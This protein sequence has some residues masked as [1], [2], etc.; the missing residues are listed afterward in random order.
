MPVKLI[1]YCMKQCQSAEG[2]ISWYN[3]CPKHMFFY[4]VDNNS[5]SKMKGVLQYMISI[6]PLA[7]P[8]RSPSCL[9]A[10]KCLIGKGWCL[11]HW[12][13]PQCIV[14]VWLWALPHFNQ[15][16]LV[17]TLPTWFVLTRAHT[18]SWE[19]SHNIAQYKLQVVT[20]YGRENLGNGFRGNV[21]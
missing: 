4:A 12:K 6:I 3:P 13:K 14:W 11:T 20:M 19:H 7:R 21:G 2:L 8:Q 10:L 1:T 16:D 17:S 18:P 5:S 15:S 9:Q